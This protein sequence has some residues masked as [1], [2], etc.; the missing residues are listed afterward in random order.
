MA[1]YYETLGVSRGADVQEIRKAYRRLAMQHHPDRNQ[2]SREAEERFKE[3]TRAYEV[4]S[5]PEKREVYDRYGERGLNRGQGG[6]GFGGF[7]FSDAI[8]IFMRDF[9]SGGGFGDLFGRR[10]PGTPRSR[11]GKG[12][13]LRL[14][15]TL[16][17]VASGVDKRLRV[18]V[19]DPCD[20]CGATGA[21][22]AGPTL[23]PGCSGTGQERI[24]Q[25]SPFGQFVSVQPCRRCG[26]E[27]QVIQDPCPACRGEGRVRE[28]STVTVE[29]PAGVSS[30]NYIT[31]RGQ[32]NAGP[33][34]GPRGDITVL[35]AVED[36][37]DFRRDGND[38][39]HELH[40]TFTQAALGDRLD[41]P[42]VEGS[43]PLSVPAGVQTGEMLRMR[44]LGVPDLEGGMR[45]DQ[46][47][48]VVVWTPENLDRRQREALE[49]LREVEDPV[50]EDAG[51]GRRG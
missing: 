38:L 7:D 31:L 37:P 41:V 47:V 43:A 20:D 26:G 49:R 32:G 9:G 15:L 11:R 14:P 27:G 36:H 34:G 22:G 28:E 12:I 13:R 16:A 48:R 40:V 29:V 10:S 8:E 35:I 18:S 42:T 45:G 19:L 24:S 50:P 5:N 30:E 4:L 2:G 44:G 21:R 33:R 3:V 23:C 39:V 25:R 51:R 1:D 6:A 46:L 17:E